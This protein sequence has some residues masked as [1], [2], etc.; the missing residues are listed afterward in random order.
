MYNDIFIFVP[1][2]KEIIRITE[3]TG[4]NLLKEDRKEGYIDYINYEQYALEQDLPDVDSGMVMLKEYFRDQ[5]TCTEECIP[6]VLDMAY[7]DSCLNYILLK[8][9]DSE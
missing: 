2:K 7:D 5:F 6:L 1:E 3:G 4:D 8:G 9:S